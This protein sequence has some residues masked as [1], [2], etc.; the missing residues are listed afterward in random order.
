MTNLVKMKR[1]DTQ[2]GLH[3]KMNISILNADELYQK[4]PE[5]FSSTF[6]KIQKKEIEKLN[7]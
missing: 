7:T 6:N 3:Q 2:K 4:Y 1:I 5:L